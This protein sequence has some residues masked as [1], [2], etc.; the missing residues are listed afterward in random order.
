MHILVQKEIGILTQDT[1]IKSHN[2]VH[3]MSM[4][5]H[6]YARWI[7]QR[8]HSPLAYTE[9]THVARNGTQCQEKII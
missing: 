8:W 6:T 7:H 3:Y 5:A 1:L 9:T 4:H 2:W